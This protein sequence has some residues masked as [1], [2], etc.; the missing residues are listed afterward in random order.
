M[1]IRYRFTSAVL[2]AL[3]LALGLSLPA[4]AQSLDYPEARRVDQ[5]D[6]YY[7][8]EVADPYRWMEDLDSDELL[9]W[10]KAQDQLRARFLG[11]DRLVKQIQARIAA[12]G[13]Y[14][15]QSMP[16]PKGRYTF[17]YQTEAGQPRGNLFVQKDGHNEPRLLLD[18]DA[19]NSDGQSA[20]VSS[21][22]PDGRYLI[23]NAAEGQSRW[24]TARLV[25]VADGAV[26]P[27]ALVGFY[28]G[29][30][31][32]A[33][34]P[35]GEGFF[36]ARYA[37][38]D[39]PQAPLG[40]PRIFYHKVG[41][42]QDDDAFIYEH[43]DDPNLSFVL[44][45]T[46]DGRYLIL[47]ASESG[48]TF[49]G[50]DDRLFYKDLRDRYSDVEELFVD[51]DATYAFEGND[52]A[53]FWIRTSYDAPSARLVEVNLE[54]PDPT[55]WR[56]MIAETDAAMQ[57]V[58]EIGDRFVVQYVKDA[59]TTARIYDAEGQLQKEID[60]LTPS[61]GGFANNPDSPITYY[62][63][64][65]LYDP[66]TI[67]RLDV[68][69][70]ETTL[71]FR[72]ELAHNPD[73]FVT[74]QAFAESKDGS[75]VPMFILH[76]KDLELDGNNPVFMYG[77]GAWGWA[78]FP[79]QRH[80]VPW[81]EMGGVYVIA[82]IRGGGEYGD[83]WHQDG[84][85]LNKQNG[86]DDFIAVAE[87][88]ID[89]DYTSPSKMIA[90]GGSASGILPGAAIIQR[91]DLFGAAVINYPTLDQVRYVEFGSAKSWIPEFG[92]PDDPDDFKALY[93]YSPYHN[94][95]EGTCYPPTWTQVGDKDDT[96]TPMHG[97]K[98]TAAMQAAQGCDNPVLLKIA[99]GAGHSSGLT[100]EQSRETL[101]E[102]L[103]FLIKVLDVDVSPFFS[104]TSGQVMKK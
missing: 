40:K 19:L 50:L 24:R 94:L 75:R 27:D 4:A 2:L 74:K 64:S 76:R 1:T 16:T 65:Q 101:A 104:P 56:E 15:S 70:G 17:F 7:G 80:M 47:S 21:Y 95:K 35:D 102:E 6:V 53:R 54:K 91:P 60:H 41:T 86:I 99:W 38:P 31:N 68:R 12:I 59:R 69:T 103:A 90:N 87:W 28:S 13:S 82:N 61:M 10:M 5:V 25:R 85:R 45:V 89:N 67:Y 55:H 39:D 32:S 96:T 14:A 58:S 92:T 73:E 66:G 48:G 98:F 84:I 88:L 71:Y 83:A 3:S 52:G 78:A 77:Y 36:Y 20:F 62:V 18:M 26:M 97:Y 9:A 11:E 23:Y 22:S 81:M 49:N 43:P 44:R 51:L 100:P 42:S 93:A 63:A 72:P 34:T 46:Y 8:V 33:W 30:T 29:R 37:V 79:W 57:S